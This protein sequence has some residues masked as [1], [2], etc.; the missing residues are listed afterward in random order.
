MLF[1]TFG[2]ENKKA[3][4]FIHG[5]LTPWQIWQSSIN[6]FSKSYFVIVPELDAHTENSVTEF[7]SIENEAAQIKE[8]LKKLCRKEIFAICGLSMGGRIAAVLAGLSE[9]NTEYLVLDGAPLLPTSSILKRIM[10]RSYLNI[11]RKT[12]KRDP[13]ILDSFKKNFL[14]EKHLENYLKIA[15][16]IEEQSLDVIPVSEGEMVSIDKNGIIERSRFTPEYDD[17]FGYCGCRAFR[18]RDDYDSYLCEY[19]SMFG[20]SEEEIMMLYDMGYDDEEIEL[21]MMD[22]DMLR[23][24]LNEAKECIGVY[25]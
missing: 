4:I 1:H 23:D 2:D 13:K 3:I 20:V 21:M 15:D 5:M 18:E 16:H 22:Y 17:F 14:P 11:I 7:I 24:C 12:K 10:I 25:M 8:Y 19:G 9:I 6:H